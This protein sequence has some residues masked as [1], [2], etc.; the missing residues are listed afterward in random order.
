MPKTDNIQAFGGVLSPVKLSDITRHLGTLKNQI[1]I[2]V[3]MIVIITDFFAYALMTKQDTVPKVC[4]ACMGGSTVI[5]F[6]LS[7]I[8][9]FYAM[10]RLPGTRQELMFEESAEKTLKAHSRVKNKPV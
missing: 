8:L 5:M 2:F 6:F 10:F 3:V 9:Y 4:G 7:L 1:L